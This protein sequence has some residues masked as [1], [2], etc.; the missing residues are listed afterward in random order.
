M[1][2]ETPTPGS[3]E[4]IEQGC[5]CPVLDN[6]HGRGARGT[7]GPDAVFW[8]SMDCPVHRYALDF[9]EQEG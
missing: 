6:A 3:A 7:S 9:L 1:G 5:T 4:A 2:S 8:M